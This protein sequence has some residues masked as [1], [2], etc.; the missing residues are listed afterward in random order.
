MKTQINNLAVYTTGDGENKAILFVHGFPCDNT[1]WEKQINYLNGSYYCVSYDIRGLGKSIVGDGQFTIEQFVDDLESIVN[2]LKIKKP[3][4]CGLS[5]GGYISLRAVEKMQNKFS[6]LILCDT[7]SAADTNEA[8]I[9]RAN[10]IKRIN[11]GDYNNFI[12][13][14]VTNCFAEEFKKKNKNEFE[15]IILRSQK[16]DPAGIKGCLLAMSAR[17]DTTSTLNKI[18]LPTLII[19]GSED[20]LTPAEVMKAMAEQISGA[21]INIINGS[22][23]MSP[24]EKP[25]EVNK[26]IETF[27][28]KLN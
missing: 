15:E 6:A 12:K 4:L 13:D 25:G 7:K 22:G 20:K 16:S 28:A 11:S 3:A 9:N 8:K 2:K 17:T 5:M 1:M 26:A 23:H 19:C 10:A 21:Q 14:F 24:V 27:L 18:K